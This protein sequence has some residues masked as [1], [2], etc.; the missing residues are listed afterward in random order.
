M[1][2]I[3]LVLH[4]LNKL[5]APERCI[6]LCFAFSLVREVCSHVVLGVNDLRISTIIPKS[7]NCCTPGQKDYYP[8]AL[9]LPNI[10]RRVKGN[11]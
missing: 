11:F 4:S 9:T 2:V 6:T 8:P 10:F 3:S 1:L 7:N 5:Y